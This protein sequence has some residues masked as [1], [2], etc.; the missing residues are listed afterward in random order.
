MASPVSNS[1][2]TALNEFGKRPRSEL[3]KS[4]K[5]RG[6]DSSLHS[7]GFKIYEAAITV[8]QSVIDVVV[9]KGNKA[10]AIFNHNESSRNDKKR[11]QYTLSTNKTN[12]VMK[13]FLESLNQYI[14]ENVSD[15]LEPATWVVIHS[16]K[17]C[18]D[19]AA[20]CDFIP[21]LKLATVPDEH[22][23][24]G[25]I[26][27]LMPGTRLNIWPC[28]IKLASIRPDLVRNREPIQCEVVE[29]NVGDM[30]VFRGDLVHAGSSYKVNNSR[31]HT[32]LD[33]YRVPRKRNR[34]WLVHTHGSE[35][36][37]KVIVPK[38]Y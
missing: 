11:R 36:M 10:P 6:S 33:S 29:L 13:K 37:R 7:V 21:D 28:S 9:N 5:R 16:K 19:Q 2:N 26:V 38:A 4:E 14:R 27:A 17:G 8:P 15:I 31:L 35:E 1:F 22:M 32:F 24:L 25:V 3:S 18:Q 30:L 34:T 12:T 23:P 20:H